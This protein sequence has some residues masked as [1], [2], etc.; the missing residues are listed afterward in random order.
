ML[1]HKNN[2]IYPLPNAGALVFLNGWPDTTMFGTLLVVDIKFS[3]GAISPTSRPKFPSS[4]PG[5]SPE[6]C[7]VLGR[8]VLILRISSAFEGPTD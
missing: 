8:G 2:G 3:E 4:P 7:M 6:L 5:R 1:V